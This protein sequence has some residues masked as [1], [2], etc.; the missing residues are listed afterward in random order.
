M[1]D[2]DKTSPPSSRPDDAPEGMAV[3]GAELL[4]HADRWI[5]GVWI[6]V[7][8]LA[9]AILP[10]ASRAREVAVAIASFCGVSLG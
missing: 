9:V 1:A 10:F 3:E 6:A 5:W 2:L 7:A 4:D 8:L